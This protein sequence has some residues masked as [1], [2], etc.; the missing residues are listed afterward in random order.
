MYILIA[1]YLNV[2]KSSLYMVPSATS[3]GRNLV[4]DVFHS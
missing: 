1:N 3:L 4:A 2:T